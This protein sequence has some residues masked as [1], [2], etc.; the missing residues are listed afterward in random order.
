MA[1]R[2]LILPF[3]LVITGLL[4]LVLAGFVFFVRAEAIGMGAHADQQQARL[5][6]ESGLEEVVAVLRVAKHNPAA[7][8]D[9]PTRFR[10]GLVW[11]PAFDRESDPVRKN[12][13][14]NDLIAPGARPAIAWR[15]SVCAPNL[16]TNLETFR[17]G[18]T[19]ESS[20]LNLSTAT[21]EQLSTLFAAQLPSLGIENVPALVDAL[22][23]WIDEDDEALPGG[24]ENTWYNTLTPPYKCKNGPLDT[25][26]ELLL[27]RGFNAII[28]WGE[29]VN[30]N[31]LLDPNEDDGAASWP[32][33]DNADGIL[34]E[35]IGPF[36]TIWSREPDTTLDNKP[37]ANLRSGAG[38]A[39][40]LQALYPDGQISAGTMAWIGQIAGNQAVLAAI[41]SPAQLYTQGYVAPVADA[42]GPASQPTSGPSSAPAGALPA[43]LL[44]SPVTAEELPFVMDGL[45]VRDPQAASATGIQGLININT[46]PPQ[47]LALVPGMTPEAAAALVAARAT[48][49]PEQ[50]TT[51]A[52]PVLTGAVDT[53]TFHAIAPWITAKAYQ[54][55][56]EI[57]GYSD[58]NKTAR[59]MEWIIEMVGPIAQ[60]KYQREL[61][62]L[63]I[64]W[65]VD[66]DSI[67]TG[68]STTVQ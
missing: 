5:A 21:R 29:D 57:V 43:E 44:S 24:A 13:S 1:R 6:A 49:P 31:G 56:V 63:G 7:W 8:F 35:G 17:Y 66:R 54:F 42:G 32:E 51:I 41:S 3:V 48:T 61:T 55:H 68:T 26:D 62:S 15:Y 30:H 52:W 45:S 23:D 10:H 40:Q 46:A 58:H 33:Y 4:A 25:V 47:V 37:R 22:T 16:A 2:G 59:R 14:R 11:S 28:L 20:K 60:I 34:N 64:A 50:L 12:G 27:I 38:A 19:P 36:I 9:V 65:P 39:A 67:V 53:N 18:V